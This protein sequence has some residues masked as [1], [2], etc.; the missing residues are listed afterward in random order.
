MRYKSNMAEA[1]AKVLRQDM[2]VL[3]KKTKQ[4]QDIGHVI[5]HDMQRVWDYQE[6]ETFFG[7]CI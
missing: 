3:I 1:Y 6:E 7:R 2:I 5:C 4:N